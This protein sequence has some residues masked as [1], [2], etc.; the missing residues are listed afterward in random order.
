MS[1]LAPERSNTFVW[2]YKAVSSAY[3]KHWQLT[4]FWRSVPCLS[5]CHQFVQNDLGLIDSLSST[6]KMNQ[7]RMAFNVRQNSTFKFCLYV[8]RRCCSFTIC[9]YICNSTFNF[10]ISLLQLTIWHCLFHNSTSKFTIQHPS[11]PNSK[12][13]FTHFNIQLWKMH[14]FDI[15][16]QS[17]QWQ[18]M[19]A[20]KTIKTLPV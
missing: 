17:S 4:L 2:I 16:P 12:S 1:V 10:P 9:T 14:V 8:W 15:Q 19:W 7:R 18:S 3:W 13:K 11:L 5:V 6:L 20:Q